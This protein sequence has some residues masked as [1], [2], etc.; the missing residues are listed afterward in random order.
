MK[1]L[2]H[3]LT[4]NLHQCKHI[5]LLFLGGFFFS[6]FGIFPVNS[7]SSS[8]FRTSTPKSKNGSVLSRDSLGFV[9]SSL[10]FSSICSDKI[11]IYIS[12]SILP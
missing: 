2:E 10:E 6:I 1:K 5:H 11:E 3:I 7:D 9:L 8:N 4:T 12:V